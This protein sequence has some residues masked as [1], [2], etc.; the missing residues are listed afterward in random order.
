M[1]RRKALLLAIFIVAF[2]LGGLATYVAL[3]VP[4]DVKA[5]GLLREARD[6]IRKQETANARGKLQRIVMEYPRTDAAAA[7]SSALFTLEADEN[8]RV[9]REVQQ[10]IETRKADQARIRTLEQRVEELAKKPAPAPAPPV[11][12]KAPAPAKKAPTRRPAR[13]TTRRRR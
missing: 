2:A 8:S 7:A 5:E 10:L 9:S 12:K 4:N 13:R 3:T 1:A 11:V 6:H